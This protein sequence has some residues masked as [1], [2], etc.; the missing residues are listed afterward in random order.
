MRRKNA[1]EVKIEQGF[2]KFGSN[3]EWIIPP[4]RTGHRLPPSQRVTAP[5][6]SHPDTPVQFAFVVRNL[7]CTQPQ[8]SPDLNPLDFYLWG[9][10]NA[11]VYAT[12][13]DDVGTLCD[14]IVTDCETIRNFAGMYQRIRVSMQR[15]VDACVPVPE[16]IMFS[17]RGGG[18]YASTGRVH[19]SY[20]AR[21]EQTPLLRTLRVAS[22]LRHFVCRVRE[23][24]RQAAPSP[25]D[26]QWTG[27]I[28]LKRAA[29]DMAQERANAKGDI[30]TQ[31]TYSIVTMQEHCTLARAGDELYAKTRL[32][33]V[34]E[35][36]GIAER[37]MEG[38]RVCEAE[39][40]ASGSHQ[41][42][43]GRARSTARLSSV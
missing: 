5:L 33:K 18:P 35:V 21:R 7:L 13:V 41:T 9:H 28:S 29:C 22:S 12:P 32:G 17:S 24:E 15:R 43:L 25:A 36:A 6:R 38:A 3:R 40:V 19:I 11:H 20:Q 27:L 8:R 26:C 4:D 39:L 37:R 2:R 16:C 10:L 31:I 42:A 34:K 1:L 23:L 30:G 14:R